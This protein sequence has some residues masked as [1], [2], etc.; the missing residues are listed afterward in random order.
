MDAEAWARID[1][2]ACYC[3]VTVFGSVTCFC[4]VDGLQRKL[5]STFQRAQDIFDDL[6][7]TVQVRSQP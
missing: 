4:S 3:N 5:G 6:S 1:P 2:A 7:L